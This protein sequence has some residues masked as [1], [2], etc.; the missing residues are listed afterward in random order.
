M[1]ERP[2]TGVALESPKNYLRGEPF[3]PPRVPA[4]CEAAS[5]K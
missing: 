2:T 4:L 1:S 5:R 3:L